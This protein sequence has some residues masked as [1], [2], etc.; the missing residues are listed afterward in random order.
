MPAKLKTAILGA[1]GYSGCELTRLLL[2]HPRVGKPLL[3]RRQSDSDAPID[4]A[5]VFPS[6]SGNGGYFLQ[7]FFWATVHVRR[8]DRLFF[9]NPHQT[10]LVVFPRAS[11]P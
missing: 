8:V 5:E 4:L 6:L 7:P 9:G 1:T 2:R 3:L 10:S 11:P